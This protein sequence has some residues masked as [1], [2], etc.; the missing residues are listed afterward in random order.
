MRGVVYIYKSLDKNGGINACIFENNKQN[1]IV[2]SNLNS[3]YFKFY[4]LNGNKIKDVKATNEKNIIIEAYKN[5]IIS[6][7]YNCCKSYNFNSKQFK[8]YKITKNGK[9]NYKFNNLIVYEDKQGIIKL[10]AKAQHTSNINRYNIII[11]DFKS[12][13][14]INK[15]DFSIIGFDSGFNLWNENYLI[16]GA[17]QKFKIYNLYKDQFTQDIQIQD[18]IYYFEIINHPKF[19]KCIMYNDFNQKI[20]I[21]HE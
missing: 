12:S 1:Y 11:W 5:F 14:F 21:M 13:N 4:D 17:G 7:H 16:L 9:T 19:G 6:G 10:I 15:I 2:T 3:Q 20:H 8:N 18:V